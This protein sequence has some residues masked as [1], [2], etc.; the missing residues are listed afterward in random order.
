MEVCTLEALKI[1][2]YQVLGGIYGPR[3]K[4]TRVNG[5]IIKCMEMGNCSGLM[6]KGMLA[7]FRMIREKVMEFL[8]GGTEEYM[9]ENG[10][11][12]N[13]MAKVNL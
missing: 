9:K 7:N 1:T 3:A 6:A 10:W 12:E 11:T 13:N 8:N 4:A 2:K 5:V